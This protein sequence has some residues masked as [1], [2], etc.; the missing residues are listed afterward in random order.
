MCLLSTAHT[1]SASP[2]SLAVATSRAVRPFWRD[3]E[4]TV[5]GERGG[6]VQGSGGEGEGGQ[7]RLKNVGRR[8]AIGGKMRMVE[9]V[10]PY[11]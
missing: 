6:R 5:K 3:T 1:P 4:Q 2:F 8:R 9:K 7:S 11:P 10:V